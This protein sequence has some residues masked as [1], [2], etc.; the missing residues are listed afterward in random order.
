LLTEDIKQESLDI[1]GV[2]SR[3]TSSGRDIHVSVET[4][5]ATYGSLYGKEPFIT[6]MAY[7][8]Y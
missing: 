3:L 6:D 5:I 2:V 8:A 4:L 1:T 7:W